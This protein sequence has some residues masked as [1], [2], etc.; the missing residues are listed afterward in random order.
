MAHI[1]FNYILL[2]SQES[3]TQ[4][5]LCLN[6]NLVL[7]LKIRNKSI[8]FLIPN[9]Q[10][11]CIELNNYANAMMNYIKNSLASLSSLANTNHLLD[12]H[13]CNATE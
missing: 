5:P 11:K 3:G 13:S 6:L 7:S 12:L 8:L 1:K 2:I 4:D 10:N 9:I